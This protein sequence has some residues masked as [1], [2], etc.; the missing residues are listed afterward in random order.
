MS[1]H[2][3]TTPSGDRRS[4][5]REPPEP[6][7]DVDTAAA[8]PRDDERSGSRPRPDEGGP[9]TDPGPEVDAAVAADHPGVAGLT[10]APPAAPSETETRRARRAE[11]R[12]GWVLW[13]VIGVPVVLVAAVVLFF[14]LRPGDGAG[15]AAATVTTTLPVPTA[16]SEPV[17]RTGAS[18]LVQAL[19]GTVRQ[20]VLASVEPTEVLDGALEA[21]TTTYSGEVLDEHGSPATASSA[22]DGGDAFTVTVGQWEDADRATAAAA[23]LATDLGTPTR[24]EDVTVGGDVTGSLA[25][26]LPDS[27]SGPS[28]E[29]TALW[30]NGTVV[31]RAVGPASELVNFATAFSL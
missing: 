16:T 30:T 31:V 23:G 3:A 14:V 9:G 19:P 2:E 27:A 8:G 17:D 11:E 7:T 28:P 15:S 21:Y 10:G 26:Y 12:R 1:E 5:R 22:A 29:A 20:F 25:F 4:S 6:G 24:T 13:A 18:A